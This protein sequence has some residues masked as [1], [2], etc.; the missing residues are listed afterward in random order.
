MEELEFRSRVRRVTGPR[1]HKVTGSWGVYDAFKWYRKNKPEGKK[2]ILNESQYFTIVRE[3]NKLLREELYKGNELVFPHKLGKLEV[4][5]YPAIITTEGKK[6]KTNLP[7]DWNATLKLWYE[8][9]EYYKSKT[10]I[11]I[12]VPEIFRIYYNKTKANYNNKS[13]Y[14]FSPNRE[15]KLGL[16]HTI[17]T[18]SSFDAFTDRL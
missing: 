3:V 14:Q 5:K 9:P 7:I 15:L 1:V 6:V 18:D 16:K 8:E 17:K 2:Y 11:R 4:R 10:L 12:N 13:F